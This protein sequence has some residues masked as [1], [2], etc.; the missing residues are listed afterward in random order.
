MEIKTRAG[1]GKPRNHSRDCTAA[2]FR[3]GCCEQVTST[4]PLIT[5]AYFSS[6]LLRIICSMYYSLSCCFSDLGHDAPKACDSM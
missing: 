5:W 6:E 2:D 1:I 3:G 4:M